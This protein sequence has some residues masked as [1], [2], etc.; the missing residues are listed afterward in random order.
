MSQV[1]AFWDPI[2]QQEVYSKTTIKTADEIISDLYEKIET[3]DKR[4]K[5]LE[6]AYMEQKLLGVEP[7]KIGT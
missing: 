6:E 4:I 7:G 2:T 3:M 1:R 5:D